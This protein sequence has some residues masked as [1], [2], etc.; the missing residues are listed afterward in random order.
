MSYDYEGLVRE[1]HHE[2]KKVFVEPEGYEVLVNA[3]NTGHIELEKKHRYVTR[4]KHAERI[5][6]D[7]RDEKKRVERIKEE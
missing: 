5:Q 7:L 3:Q 1:V 6:N 4:D 2:T